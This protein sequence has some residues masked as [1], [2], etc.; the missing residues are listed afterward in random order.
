[1]CLKYLVLLKISDATLSE[2]AFEDQTGL[3]QAWTAFQ[4]LLSGTAHTILSLTSENLTKLYTQITPTGLAL[5]P[6]FQPI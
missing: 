2:A 4:S 5:F 1:M 3:K 6:I